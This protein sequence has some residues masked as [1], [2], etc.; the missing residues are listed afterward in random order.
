MLISLLRNDEERVNN[1]LEWKIFN[2]LF[3]AL[4]CLLLIPAIH[5]SFTVLSNAQDKYQLMLI[6]RLP[7]VLGTKVTK[8]SPEYEY[9]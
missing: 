3:L 7:V 5:Q 6:I 1:C 9:Y 2:S 4:E 8:E